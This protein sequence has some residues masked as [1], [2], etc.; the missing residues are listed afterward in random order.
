VGEIERSLYNVALAN[1]GPG[2]SGIRYFT[3]LHK[4]KQTP[5]DIVSCCE[6]QG[7]RWLGA[8]QEFLFSVAPTT[9]TPAVYVDMY[10]PASFITPVP[11]YAGAGVN[12]TVVTQWPFGTAVTVL[13]A[14]AGTGPLTMDLALRI[15]AWTTGN[16]AVTVDGVPWGSLG[17]P[18]SYL[19]VNREWLGGGTAT[20]VSFSLPATFAAH[21]YTGFTQLPPYQRYAY[22]YGPLL[23]AAEGP[24]SLWNATVDCLLI[25]GVDP[26]QPVNWMRQV[27]PLMWN[28]TTSSGAQVTFFP[29]FQVQQET[30]T[31]YP[32]VIAPSGQ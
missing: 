8:I 10:A 15:P 2:G 26:L 5:D 18:G 23:L 30:F 25:D 17:T 16:V 28:V 31:A 20:P 21:P 27:G 4:S 13:V 14:P 11:G 9:P 6:G 22:T 19:H 32:I 3:N 7:T 1:Q 29:Y 24:S 12:V